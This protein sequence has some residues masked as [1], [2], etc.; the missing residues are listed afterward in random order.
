MFTRWIK[1]IFM[2]CKPLYPLFFQPF[3]TDSLVD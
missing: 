3:L 1:G 2:S